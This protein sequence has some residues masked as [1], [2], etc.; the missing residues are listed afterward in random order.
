MSFFSLDRAETTP[1]VLLGLLVAAC[2]GQNTAV[3]V[4]PDEH[5]VQIAGQCIELLE[6][7]SETDLEQA[8][9]RELEW[10]MEEALLNQDLCAEA[11]RASYRGPGGQ[12]MANH[13]SHAL[14]LHAL[15]AELSLSAR[16]DSMSNYCE[17]LQ[18]IIA[19]I[20]VDLAEV[21]GALQDADDSDAPSLLALR[22]LTL[23]AL[24]ISG[25]DFQE[26]CL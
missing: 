22:E 17:I 3:E 24:Q 1:I 14:A 4:P 20:D 23:Q 11:L 7:Y 18:D 26:T 21:D 5:M 12:V 13:L 15:Y 9:E 10:Q 2:S 8:S 19:L 6:L 25:F 16:F